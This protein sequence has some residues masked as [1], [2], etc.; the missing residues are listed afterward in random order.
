MKKNN[1]PNVVF[2]P[3]DCVFLGKLVLGKMAYHPRTRVRDL[4]PEEQRRLFVI[5]QKIKEQVNQPGGVI[6]AAIKNPITPEVLKAI[7]GRRI[8]NLYK[9]NCG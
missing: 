9:E 1:E 5:D 6:L 7:R 8:Y 2:P 4:E 3:F